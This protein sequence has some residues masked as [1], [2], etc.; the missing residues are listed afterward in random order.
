[1]EGLTG[2]TVD[3]YMIVDFAGFREVIDAIGGVKA[4]VGHGVFP[5]K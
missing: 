4:D 3:N 5:E 2:V 1:M